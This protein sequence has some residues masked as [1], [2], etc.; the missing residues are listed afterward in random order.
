MAIYRIKYLKQCEHIM[1]VDAD[2]EDEAIKKFKHLDCIK[3][4]E[5]QCLDNDLIEIEKLVL[6]PTQ[7]KNWEKEYTR[8]SSEAKGH[9]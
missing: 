8:D 6:S 2:S 4:Y 5:Y 7:K 9:A 3:D 1:K